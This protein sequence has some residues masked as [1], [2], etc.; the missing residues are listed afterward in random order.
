MQS[1]GHVQYPE[2]RVLKKL[3]NTT[4]PKKIKK[5]KRKKK[6]IFLVSQRNQ[7]K[8]NLELLY[9]AEGKKKMGPPAFSFIPNEPQEIL[10]LHSLIVN[11][12]EI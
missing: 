10:G 8:I 1:C 3:K 12:I 9:L 4:F 7:I 5:K 6:T 2:I 11:K